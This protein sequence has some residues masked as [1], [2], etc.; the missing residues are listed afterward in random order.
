MKRTR[1]FRIL[2]HFRRRSRGLGGA[3]GST[4]VETAVCFLI[5]MMMVIGIMEVCLLFYAYNF[6]SEAAR[7][8]AR[9]AIVRGSTSCTNTPGLASC[10]ASAAT[11]QSYVL[12]L[13]YPGLSS[14][15]MSV[16]VSYET[17]VSSGSPATTTWTACSSGTCNAPGNAVNVQVIY[18]F[19]LAVPGLR[20]T[21]LNLSENSQMVIAQ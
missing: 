19:P 3:D 17:A 18:A 8:G 9:W 2:G 4:L 13:N 20:L 1:P 14:A 15:N 16:N 5:Y 10:D 7:E 21:A 11:I 6:V 12:G